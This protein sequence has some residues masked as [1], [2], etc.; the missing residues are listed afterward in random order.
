MTSLTA[1]LLTTQRKL[2]WRLQGVTWQDQ[3]LAEKSNS[4]FD[5]LILGLSLL[6]CREKTLH[7]KHFF[8]I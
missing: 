7:G 3:L 6:S 8:N 2:L 5:M 1:A 4:T